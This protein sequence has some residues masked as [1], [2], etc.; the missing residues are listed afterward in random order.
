M[1]GAA[2]TTIANLCIIGDYYK[3][4][5][6]TLKGKYGQKRLLK[7]A[8]MAAL[9]AT[10]GVTHPRDLNK[11]RSLYDEVDSHNKALSLLGIPGEHYSV[12]MLPELMRKLPRDIAIN[13]RR[14]KEVNREWK[15]D[16]FL[17]QFWQELVLRSA[18]LV[19]SRT[20][21]RQWEE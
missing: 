10:Q 12:A 6:E 17:E 8:H 5:I 19:M 16:E 11:S 1:D 3:P 18:Q 20:S 7:G 14:S 9:K 15:I 13:I 21:S 2:S 4:A